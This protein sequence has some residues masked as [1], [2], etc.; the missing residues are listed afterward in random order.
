MA[1]RYCSFSEN[2]GLLRIPSRFRKRNSE[3][4]KCEGPTSKLIPLRHYSLGNN[5]QLIPTHSET[6]LAESIDQTFID[7]TV[8][9]IDQIGSNIGI[10]SYL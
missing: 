2:S 3:I 8:Q 4:S 9:T 10:L 7:Q 1:A 5:M 6:N